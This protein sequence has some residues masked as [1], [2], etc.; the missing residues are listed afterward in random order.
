MPLPIGILSLISVL[1]ISIVG[2]IVGCRGN[3]VGK[4]SSIGGEGDADTG[5]FTGGDNTS[6]ATACVGGELG[7]I[8]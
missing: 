2:E 6:I 7:G 4:T 3:S 8:K 1:V 5:S